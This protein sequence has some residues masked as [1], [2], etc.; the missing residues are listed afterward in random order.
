MVTKNEFAK[1]RQQIIKKIGRSG[2]VIL[3][4]APVVPRNGDA[5]Y[6]YRQNNDFYYLTG[7][8]EPE[9]VAII[10][11]NRKEGEFILFNRVRYREEEIW[12]GFRAGQEG[13]CKGFGVDEAFPISE[14]EERLP[15]F[16]EGREEIYYTI[17]LDH[18]FDK[19]VLKAMNKI[20]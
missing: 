14:L 17:G 1:R 8:E 4:A 19:I 15:T 3:A 13:A 18:V 7:F 2:I 11:P 6:P 16:L 10:A 12:T 5:N 20:R 9:S